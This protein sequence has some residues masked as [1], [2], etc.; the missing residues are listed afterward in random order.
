MLYDKRWDAKVEQKAEPFSLGSL[1]AWL[2][3]QPK[4]EVYCWNN[5]GECLMGQYARHID[6]L[7]HFFPFANSTD[8]YKY[9]IDGKIVDFGEFG[10]IASETPRTFG[11]ALKRAR[12]AQ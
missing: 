10:K 8:L 12:A 7:S 11:A 1:I 3:K 5:V 9:V 4:D 6:P 2:E